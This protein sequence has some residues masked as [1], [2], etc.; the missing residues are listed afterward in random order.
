MSAMNEFT[1]QEAVI[2]IDYCNLPIRCRYCLSPDHLVKDCAWI[3]GGTSEEVAPVEESASKIPSDNVGS[4]E[5]LS[6]PPAVP[7]GVIPTRLGEQSVPTMKGHTRSDHTHAGSS[8]NGEARAGRTSSGPNNGAQ[9]N[10]N[11]QDDGQNPIAEGLGARGSDSSDQ[12]SKSGDRT[13]EEYRSTP[14][15]EWNGWEKVYRGRKKTWGPVGTGSQ[16]ENRGTR[17]EHRQPSPI[18]RLQAPNVPRRSP[19]WGEDRPI[20]QSQG[21]DRIEPQSTGVASMDWAS[22]EPRQRTGEVSSDPHTRRQGGDA[23][24]PQAN[25]EG[26][27][28]PITTPMNKDKS[29]QRPE[30]HGI[31]PPALNKH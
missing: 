9:T 1:G 8:K 22:Q 10:P 23:K 16:Q 29:Q 25:Q 2:L 18:E 27:P 3:S 15:Y 28:T 31:L 12:R 4:K 13:S 11:N 21:Q 19:G 24:T 14:E 17:N 5:K 20:P 7:A 26:V 6:D 30:I